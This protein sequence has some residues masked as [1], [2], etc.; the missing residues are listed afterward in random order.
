M[1]GSRSVGGTA[2]EQWICASPSLDGL[3]CPPGC[4]ETSV[5]SGVE[6]FPADPVHSAQL[7]RHPSEGVNLECIEET[8]CSQ[9]WSPQGCRLSCQE[10]GRSQGAATADH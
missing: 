4:N 2:M 10:L 1:R 9:F 3:V 6:Q 7:L 8:V 5:S